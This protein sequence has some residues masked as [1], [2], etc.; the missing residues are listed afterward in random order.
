MAEIESTQILKNLHNVLAEANNRFEKEFDIQEIKLN[1]NFK[2]LFK[3]YLAKKHQTVD[4]YDYTTVVTNS[5]NQKIYIANQWFVIAA[6]YVDFCAEML[7]YRDLFARVCRRMGMDNHSMKDYAYQL[8]C[9]PY[10]SNEKQFKNEAFALLKDNFDGSNEELEKATT[11]LWKFASDYQWWNGNKSIDRHDFYESALLNQMGVVNASAEY[12]AVIT[13]AYST[14]LRLRVAVENI[15]NFTIDFKKSTRIL[16]ND[17]Y[18][19]EEITP[20]HIYST[21]DTPNFHGISIS[22]ASLNRFK[23]IK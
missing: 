10:A 9:A 5:C 1:D 22:A 15:E 8:R 17:N 2:L 14:D 12:L 6:Y 21:D 4:Y 19:F 16:D 11:Y 20:T 13:F 3:G 18:D 23:G 7:T